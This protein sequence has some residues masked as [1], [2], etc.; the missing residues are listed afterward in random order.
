MANP[1]LEWA[2][3][4][5]D[6]HEFA[7]VALIELLN[8][9]VDIVVPLVVRR[10]PPFIPV[11]FMGGILGRLLKEFAVTICVAILISGGVLEACPE[12]RVCIAHELRIVNLC[13]NGAVF[14]QFFV[15]ASLGNHA[16]VEHD[17]AVGAADGGQAVGDDKAGAA[18]HE[19][20]HPPLDQSFGQ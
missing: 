14:H 9:Q 4:M 3:I 16:V 15:I 18:G 20:L 19:L 1:L 6:D 11:L 13:V 2:W 17:D 7:N 12:L 10:Q 5:G 8:T